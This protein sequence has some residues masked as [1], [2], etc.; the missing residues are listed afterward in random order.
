MCLFLLVKIS[1]GRVKLVTCP[2]VALIDYIFC[3]CMTLVNHE[4]LSPDGLLEYHG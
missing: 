3:F 2:V 1:H 4:T